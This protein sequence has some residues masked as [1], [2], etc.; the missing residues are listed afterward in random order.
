MIIAF[1]DV[2]GTSDVG[3]EYGRCLG[4]AAADIDGDGWLDLYV[5]ND[6]TANQLWINRAA[7]PGAAGRRICYRR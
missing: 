1:E 5:A 6:G 3:R 2:T 7:E 4:A